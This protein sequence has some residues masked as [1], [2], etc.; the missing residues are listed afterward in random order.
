M[1]VHSKAEVMYE[2]QVGLGWGF[3]FGVFQA[4]CWEG[5]VGGCAGGASCGGRAGFVGGGGL[6][7]AAR[8]ALSA[9]ASLAASAAAAHS[10]S[11]RL[12]WVAAL[13]S[14]TSLRRLL[15]VVGAANG[16]ANGG[17]SNRKGAAVASSFAFFGDADREGD[18]GEASAAT[19]PSRRARFWCG[20]MVV[21]RRK[22]ALQV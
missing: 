10:S 15:S 11:V 18:V 19:C 5:V 9:V 2:G 4:G 14:L 22:E 13:R 17:G 1:T 12:N 16:V 21:V 20:I 8:A 6:Q 3:F 7:G